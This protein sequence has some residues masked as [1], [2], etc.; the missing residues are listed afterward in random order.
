M[1]VFGREFCDFVVW[2]TKDCRR[3]SVER[4][5][6]VINKEIIPKVSAF[7]SDNMVPAIAKRLY[8]SG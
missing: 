4:D 2:T 7:Y 6:N 8:S 3:L 5:E 1:F